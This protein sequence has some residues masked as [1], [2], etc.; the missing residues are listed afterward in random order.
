MGFVLNYLGIASGEMLQKL[1]DLGITLL[2][3]TVGLKLDLKMLLRPQVWATPTVTSCSEPARS[4]A[5]ERSVS[6]S[7][8]AWGV[9]D[10]RTPAAATAPVT[11]RT[12]AP[13]SSSMPMSRSARST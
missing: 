13:A 9:P 10:V 7:A 1:A 12:A 2:L 6:G 4:P 3:F 8:A 11:T 5:A